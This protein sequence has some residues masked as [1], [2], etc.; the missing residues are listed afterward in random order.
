MQFCLLFVKT[1]SKFWI[2]WT[3]SVHLLTMDTCWGW[4]LQR[5]V[6]TFFVLWL[7][8][9]KSM[10][11]STVFYF[12]WLDVF[13]HYLWLHLIIHAYTTRLLPNIFNCAFKLSKQ[14]ANIDV[15][16][17]FP[18]HLFIFVTLMKEI[19]YSFY[20]SLPT[21]AVYFIC[22]PESIYLFSYVPTIM[23]LHSYLRFLHVLN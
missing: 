15:S 16:Y 23:A 9:I 19:L 11:T 17:K 21:I 22:Y 8:A 7:L 10:S 13:S 2:P 18:Q 3:W 1:Y 12:I 20:L 6:Y 5:E 14:S 4:K